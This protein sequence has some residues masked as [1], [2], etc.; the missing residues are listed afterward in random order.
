MF[1]ELF[2]LSWWGQVIAGVAVFLIGIDN[3]G[4]G[5]KKIAGSKLKDLI[6]KFTSSSIKG[7]LVGIVITVLIQ[8]SS[9]TTTLVIGLI[10]AGIMTLKQGFRV[11][12]GANIGTTITAFLI[13]LNIAPFA[14]F[15][16]LIGVL[17]LLFMSKAK[18][19]AAGQTL[20][21]FGIIF[22]G[23]T[24]MEGSLKPIAALP[25]FSNLISGLSN[26]PLLGLIVGTLAT[27][28]IQSSSAFIGV[29]QAIYSTSVEVGVA[30]FTLRTVIPLLIGSNLGTT[31][32]G[33]L[34]ALSGKP[35]AKRAAT[36]HVI[37]NLIGA[38][39]FMILLVPYSNLMTFISTAL[40]ISPKMQIA[41][42]HIIFNLIT[43]VALFPLVKY[44]VILIEKMIPRKAGEA[45][46][47]DLSSLNH[48]ITDI[49]PM[50]ALE[51]A[52]KETVVM[53][54]FA[55]QS[56]E[57]LISYLDTKNKDY[58]DLVF[59]IE[60]TVDL[61]NEKLTMFLQKME[62]VKLRD[63]DVKMYTVVLK[64]FRDIERIS[65][66]CENIAEFIRDCYEANQE[67]SNESYK[68]IRKLL[69]LA[70]RMT[71]ESI[72]IFEKNSKRNSEHILVLEEEMDDIYKEA[73]HAHS[74]RMANNTENITSITNIVFCDI[75]TN[76]E[77][78]GDHCTN[79]IEDCE[80]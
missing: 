78:I 17:L 53:G 68:D 7:I 32:T 73:R 54:N 29:L 3:M 58:K 52:R 45:L 59:S 47:V 76:I 74:E 44:I 23:L 56:I 35:D 49:S 40:N 70:L 48:N 6:D 64:A 51:I 10:S 75:I 71:K 80:F 18:A 55:V 4:D 20:F 42:S 37:F 72:S 14:P 69:E 38:L 8:S 62:K 16:M 11:I 67:F 22:F 25:E 50:T 36:F 46:Q 41:Y 27:A 79:I 13:G 61:F 5:L 15:I 24:L 9:A 57:N 39:L 31:I 21:G 26:N 34:A 66:H 19:K 1:K 12:M 2:D 33:I 63:K 43:T 65:D 28:A 60:E 77:R 30:D